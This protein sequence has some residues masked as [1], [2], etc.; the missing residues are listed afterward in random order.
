M[1]EKHKKRINR[2]KRVR[3]RIKGT[4][5]VP[6]LCVFRSNSHIYAKLVDDSKGKTILQAKDVDIAK[7]ERKTEIKLEVAPLKN[8]KKSKD[9]KESKDSKEVILKG[10]V[11]LAYQVGEV[12]AQ[13]S[14]EK[15]IKRVVFDRGG[16]KYHG[17][18][19]ALADGARK[20]GLVI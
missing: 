3:A 18:I 4:N 14:Q 6:R 11:A 19:K 15:S 13:M 17:R 7:K 2:H 9:I 16:Y 10:K 1:L 8:Q 12:I 5:K 20:G